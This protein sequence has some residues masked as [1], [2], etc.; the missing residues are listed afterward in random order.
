MRHLHVFLLT[1]LLDDQDTELICGRIRSITTG[2]EATFE[3]VE[4]LAAWIRDV[5]AGRPGWPN[6]SAL[7]RK[8]A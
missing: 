3:R 4:E 7:E 8:D 6:S 2:E 5:N 1:L